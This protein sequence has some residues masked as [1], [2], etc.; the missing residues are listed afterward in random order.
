MN[1]KELLERV[2][3][4]FPMITNATRE[5]CIQIIIMNYVDMMI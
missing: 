2:K 1:D 4:D 5:E 3:R